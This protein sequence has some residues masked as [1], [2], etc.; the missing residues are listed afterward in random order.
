[1]KPK[2]KRDDH[3]REVRVSKAVHARI[4]TLKEQRGGQSIPVIATELLEAALDALD[5]KAVPRGRK[6]S[7][8]ISESS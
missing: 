1:M 6:Q 5:E 2:R 4:R 3:L 8:K 7:R